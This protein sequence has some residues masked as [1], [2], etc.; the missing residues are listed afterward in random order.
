MQNDSDLKAAGA[1]CVSVP[2]AGGELR[3]SVPEA[4][5]PQLHAL[6]GFAS[7]HNPKR[8]F[9]F[10]SRVLGKHLPVRPSL[11]LQS[12]AQLAALLQPTLADGA[13]FLGFAETATGLGAGVFEACLRRKPH[14]AYGFIQTTR[15]ALSRPVALHFQEEHSHSTGHLLYE[16]ET[17]AIRLDAQTVVLVDDELSTGKTAVNFTQALRAVNKRLQRVVLVSLVNWMGPEKKAAVRAALPDLD[18]QF[19]S[20]LDGS[21]EFEANPAYRC[22]AMPCVDSSSAPKDMVLPRSYGRMGAHTLHPLWAEK[23]LTRLSLDKTRPVHVLGDGEFMHPPLLLASQL[24]KAGFAVRF[25]S[26]TRSP[27]LVGGAITEK[28]CFEDHYG[29]GIENFAYNLP[30]PTGPAQVVLCHESSGPLHLAAAYPLK[31]VSYQ[32]L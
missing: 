14:A 24:E 1:A 11:V 10:V 32:E 26:T 29:D 9:L 28:T 15:Y 21:F 13:L 7:R 5:V 18:V 17:S 30:D 3:V 23:A 2:L 22:P 27:I 12:H 19:V 20:L 31:T 8:G 25:Q 4:A 6:C 16:P